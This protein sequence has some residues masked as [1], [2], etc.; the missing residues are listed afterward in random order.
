VH[1]NLHL[2]RARLWHPAGRAF[3]GGFQIIGDIATDAGFTPAIAIWWAFGRLADVRV[4]PGIPSTLPAIENVARGPLATVIRPKT[5]LAA[6]L[7]V[8]IPKEGGAG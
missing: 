3:D 6:S 1:C 8:N 2:K 4:P 5:V 7:G